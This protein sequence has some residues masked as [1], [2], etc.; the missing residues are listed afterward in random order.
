MHLKSLTLVSI[1]A[2]AAQTVTAQEVG[3][4]SVGIGA[5]SMGAS[6]EVQ[7]GV[8]PNIAVRGMV[9]GGINLEDEF[10]VDDGTLDGEAELG[11]VAVV[12]DYYPFANPWRVSGGLFFSNFS[13]SGEYTEDGT[14]YD[15]EVE[16]KQDVVPM[17]TTGFDYEFT[18]GWSL[19]GDIGVL[20]SPLEASSDSADPLVQDDVD[21][22]NADLEDVPVFPFVGLAVTYTY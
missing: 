14:T 9:M 6:L 4:L 17:L 22:L 16:F 19:T 2:A 21:E 11:G 10:D 3:D 8:T 7:Y 15:A 1:F 13:L 12:A 20:I 18:Q 5:T